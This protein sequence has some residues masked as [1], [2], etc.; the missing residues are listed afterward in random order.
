M[1]REPRFSLGGVL[2]GL[3]CIAIGMLFVLEV[4]GSLVVKPDILWPASVVGL[5]VIFVV[6]AVRR[7][8]DRQ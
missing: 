2:A 3:L 4:A 6:E 5:G 8:A 1:A 7:Q